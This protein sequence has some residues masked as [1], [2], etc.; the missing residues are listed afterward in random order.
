MTHE[1]TPSKWPPLLVI[2]LTGGIASG[3]STVARMFADLGA[4]VLNAD[5][6]GRAV[7]E[8]GEAA[9]AEIVAAFGREY[10]LPDGRLDRRALGDRIFH[11]RR[12][13]EILNRITHP[14]IGERLCHKLRKLARDTPSPPLVV[15]EA[16]VLIEAGWGPL[17]DKIIVVTAQHS[18]Q[19]ARLMAGFGMTALQAEARVHAQLPLRKRLRY[20]DYRV[21]GD[22]PLS[23]THAQVS[24]L[25]KDLLRELRTG[26]DAGAR[27]P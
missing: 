14:R 22:A 21:R 2:G 27:R 3:K 26:T 10:L 8:P 15:V 16:A 23:E 5:D 18:T 11:A 20:A 25:W 1:R 7:A 17:V 12:D 24:A 19:V 4:A 13:R 9:L 6:E